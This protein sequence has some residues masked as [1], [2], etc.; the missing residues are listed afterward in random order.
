MGQVEYC[1]RK[2]SDSQPKEIFVGVVPLGVPG[3]EKNGGG[4]SD[5]KQFCDAVK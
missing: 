4:N 1:N 5:A 2:I 3:N